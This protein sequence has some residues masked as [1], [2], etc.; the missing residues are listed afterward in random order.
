MVARPFDGRE[1]GAQIG[2]LGAPLPELTVFGMMLGSGKEIIHFMRATRS[3]TS[4]LYVAKRLSR[5][6]RDVLRHGRGMTL[7]NGNALTGRLAKSAFDLKIPLWLSSP[8]RELIVEDGAVC[9]AIVQLFRFSASMLPHS[10]LGGWA[11]NPKKLRLAAAKMRYPMLIE[12]AT[13]R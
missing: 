11:P 6:F 5:H 1:L 4:A 12:K 7:T 13:I 3:L 9:G 8:V 10:G 2:N